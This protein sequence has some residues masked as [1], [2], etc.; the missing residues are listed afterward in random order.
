MSVTVFLKCNTYCASSSSVPRLMTALRRGFHNLHMGSSNISP[1]SHWPFCSA[2]SFRKCNGISL[3]NNNNNNNSSSLQNARIHPVHSPIVGV[4]MCN[5]TKS[6][7]VTTK[8]AKNYHSSSKDYRFKFTKG[9]STL[10]NSQGPLVGGRGR[11]KGVGGEGVPT[12][13]LVV[14]TEGPSELSLESSF[15]QVSGDLEQESEDA[16]SGDSF[17]RGTYQSPEVVAAVPHGHSSPHAHQVAISEAEVGLMAELEDAL[18]FPLSLAPQRPAPKPLV[19]V[20][21]GPSGVGKDAVIKKLQHTRG[22]I[23]FVVTAT[24]RPMRPGE[25]DG[26]DYYFMSK[27]EFQEMIENH[28]LLEHAIVYG[29]YKG[30]P[31]QQVREFMSQG[32]DVVLRVDVQG[33]ATVRSILGSEAIFI[34]LVAE[35]EMALVKRLIERKTETMD[36]ML[37]R[38]AT[39]REELTRMEEFDYVVVNEEGCLDGTVSLICSIIDA[40]KARVKPK[41]AEI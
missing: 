16:Q 29:D 34:F 5:S 8:E 17:P 39:A 3:I 30:I 4:T 11:K 1:L 35:S 7:H 27:T 22:D 14:T 10:A 36:K 21:S 32:M 37:V 25:V 19:I 26:V 9:G 38:V 28:E 23:H 40:E 18:G 15:G 33:A 41:S 2:H 31:K 20:I 13:P 12:K 6:S 24:T